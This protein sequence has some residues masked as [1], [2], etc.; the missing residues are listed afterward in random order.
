MTQIVADPDSPAFKTAETVRGEWVIRIDGEVKARTPTPST[1]TCRPAR[2]RCS[3]R[4]RSPV[5]APRNCRCRCLASRTTRKT[6]ASSYRFLDL[7][8]ETLHANIMT[9]TKVIAEMRKRM[10]EIGFAEFADADPDR[11]VAGR[12]AR[13][14]GAEPHPPRQ[15]LRAA[16]GTAAVQAAADGVGLRPLLPDRAVLPRRR[17]AR[18]PAAGRVL[19]ARPRD[20]LRDPG[21]CLGHDGAGDARRVRGLPTASR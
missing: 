14:P 10:T 17:P 15:V 5:E 18:R 6:C 2:S 11:L 7:R 20:E 8:R 1:P 13:L 9:R 3:H 19:P 12:R 16:A 4:D 21:R